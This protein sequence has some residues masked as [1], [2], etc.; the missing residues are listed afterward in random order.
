MTR[1]EV[2]REWFPASQELA[3]DMV[4]LRESTVNLPPT[5]IVINETFEFSKRE[6]PTE[7]A[8]EHPGESR[9]R[10]VDYVYRYR[11]P[12]ENPMTGEP[13]TRVFCLCGY[14]EYRS[15]E[16]VAGDAH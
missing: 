1:T 2:A 16:V 12:H 11:Q 13:E 8:D 5:L 15:K 3:R 9:C 4:G 10:G 14:T 7:C 6:N